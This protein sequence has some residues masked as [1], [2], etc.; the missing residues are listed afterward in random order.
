MIIQNVSKMYIVLADSVKHYASLKPGQ[1]TYL[2][3]TMLEVE[4]ISRPLADGLLKVVASGGKPEPLVTTTP[5][6]ARAR[7]VEEIISKI[8]KPETEDVDDGQPIISAGKQGTDYVENANSKPAKKG[9]MSDEGQ[10]IVRGKGTK[11]KLVPVVK[12]VAESQGT[13]VKKP[14]FIKVIGDGG[15]VALDNGG[16][17]GTLIINESGVPGQARTV[18][19]NEANTEDLATAR[20]MTDAILDEAEKGRKLAIYMTADETVR[21]K[22]IDNS[23]DVAFLK[24]V[25]TIEWQAEAAKAVRSKLAS[26]GV[27]ADE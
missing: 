12:P 8:S 25:A 22:F 7:K 16:I 11:K 24:E 18:S 20:K 13:V 1:K 3:D 23:K 6:P 10:Q 26:L 5:L 21:L 15:D 2:D 9:K 14:N 27:A 4:C 17:D 19:I